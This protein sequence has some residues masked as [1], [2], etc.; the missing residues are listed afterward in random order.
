[1]K[2]ELFHRVM[3]VVLKRI[4]ILFIAVVAMGDLQ[5]QTKDNS[6]QPLN[7]GIIP[8][9]KVSNL[10][11]DET[12]PMKID[13]LHI[14]IKVL[15]QIAVTTLEISYLNTNSR[16]ME[17]EFNFPLGEGQTVSRFALD[18]NGQM[19]EGVVVEKEEGR[20]TFEAVVRRGVD[21]GLLE[22]T[23]GNNFRARVYPLPAHG[24]RKIIIAYEQELT[25]NGQGYL[26]QLPLE[27]KDEIR[28]FSIHAEIIKEPVKFKIDE[29]ELSNFKF[30]KWNDSW[31]ADFKKENYIPDKQLAFMIP[32]ETG[33]ITCYTEAF[34]ENSESSYF[35]INIKPKLFG[36][37]KEL[38]HKIT[39]FWD[40]SN[41][42]S[43][44]DIE[45]EFLILDGYFRKIGTLS[46]ELVP[47][48]IAIE[49][50]KI[51]KIIDGNWT[52]LQNALTNMIYDGGTSFGKIDFSKYTADEFLLFSDGIS[53]FGQSHPIFG[54]KPVITIN[55][56]IIANHSF[57]NYIA[58]NSG[59]QYINLTKL[60][61]SEAIG[62]LSKSNYHFISAIVKQGDISQLYPST[63]SQFSYTFGQ[64][65]IIKGKTAIIT[66]N[67][68]FGTTIVN[69]E[70][71]TISA[72]K[73]VNTGIIRRVWA[74][75]KLADLNFNEDENKDEITQLGKDYGVVTSNTS[76]IVLEN[77]SDYLQHHIV[78][79][80]EMQSEY[81]SSV[82]KVKQ[83]KEN[84]VKEHLD[85]AATLLNNRIDWWNKVYTESKIRTTSL[86][87]SVAV[88]P[89]TNIGEDAPA[90]M[91]V[92]EANASSQ[93]EAQSLEETVVI[94]YG[95]QRRSDITGAIAGTA[96]SDNS[97]GE[98]WKSE[99]TSTA[100]MQINA[101]DPKTPYIK[102]LQ[103]AIIGDEYATYLKLK[104]EYGNTP[105]FFIDASDFFVKSG[106]TDTALKILSNLAELKLEEPNLLRILGTKLL[107]MN[108]NTEAVEVFKKVLQMKEEEPQSY[109]DLG[110]AYESDGQYQLAISTLYEAVKRSWDSRFPEIELIII[111][112]L[113]NIIANH[114][115]KLN[116][117]FIDKRLIFNLAVDIRVV[118]TWDTDNCD[119]D[120]W[121][122]DPNGEKCF[123]SHAETQAGGHISRDFTGGYGPE[124]FM[125]KKAINGEYMVQANYF[126]THTQDILA[127]VTLH[128]TFYTNYGKKD[129][130]KQV[131]TIRLE[132]KQDIIDIGKYSFKPTNNK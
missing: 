131:T 67:F 8:V 102:V 27:M 68:G 129:Q 118:L 40:N 61:M 92:F 29:N 76:L 55:S 130:Q 82:N 56:S 37:E 4:S 108:K 54:S 103:Y 123:Y 33:K 35:Y 32:T 111:E 84:Q 74:E 119:M 13:E 132:N 36:K 90:L 26:Y 95:T 18:I 88:D 25:D 1:M 79:P 113:N 78:P 6:N 107:E 46:L 70:N 49:K 116:Y 122:I 124:E 81:F 125:V 24:A 99:S 20:K 87:A 14:D 66:L 50:S 112:E 106:K 69:S 16:V 85:Y 38:P 97:G 53:N 86:E 12:D 41:S 58:Q 51:F 5:S 34:E 91:M 15:G 94:G 104:K 59:G 28:S 30:E 48:N 75:K 47:F 11:K 22:K 121:V 23:E 80:I 43:M 19:R 110:L 60:N 109:R 77:L 17:G 62:I 2:N 114:N 45:K 57:L 10:Q 120:L 83:D 105:F 126:G 21:P 100:S 72:D 73:V 64:S 9:M 98:T 39:L 63:P 89:N 71:V 3:H 44:R 31:I 52:D 128:L 7:P 115:L 65:G 42:A 117:S 96:V 101:W 93:P 127:P